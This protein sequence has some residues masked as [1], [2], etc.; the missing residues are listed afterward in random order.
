MK[1]RCCIILVCGWLGTMVMAENITYIDLV[2]RLTDL[3]RLA[4][5]PSPGDTCGQWSS[6]D[7]KSC[8][9]VGTGK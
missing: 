5:L 4:V 7:R 6:Y 8:F 1:R 9:D 3:E 2:K